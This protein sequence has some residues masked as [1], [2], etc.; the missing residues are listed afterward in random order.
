MIRCFWSCSVVG[1]A[2]DHNG[3]EVLTRSSS[4]GQVDSFWDDA[5]FDDADFT[6]I[7]AIK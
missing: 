3:C 1:V 6:A 5:E 4:L 7:D 2:T